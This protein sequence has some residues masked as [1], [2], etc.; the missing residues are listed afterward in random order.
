MKKLKHILSITAL[1]AL[2]SACSEKIPAPV[3][4]VGEIG[5]TI[6][7]GAGI[8]NSKAGLETKAIDGNHAKHVNMTES[9]Q[10]RLR[11]DGT[12][13]GKGLASDLVSKSTTGTINQ[14]TGT[15][16]KHNKINFSSTEQLYWDD[17]GTADPANTTSRSNGLT[18]YGI[19]VDGVSSAPAV[20]NWNNL[21]WPLVADQTEGWSSKDLLTSNN[22]RSGADG[23]LKF[24]EWKTYLAD[25]STAVSN[26]LEFTH[27]L[28]K[29][30][31]ILTAGQGFEESKFKTNPSVKLK[32]FKING[33]VDIE[34][35][36]TT[37]SGEAAEISAHLASGGANSNTAQFD[38]LV[39]PGTGWNNDTK[40]DELLELS[41]DGNVYHVSALKLYEKMT[42]V[43]H[44]QM[45]KGVNYVLNITVN[46][47]G[48]DVTA[49]IKDWE[50]V[51][52]ANEAPVIAISKTYGEGTTDFAKGFTFYRS[53]S[54]NGSYLGTGDNSAVSS[55]YTM[56]PKLYWPDHSTHY[57]FRGVWPAVGSTDGAAVA[58]LHDENDKT[59]IDVENCQYQQGKYPSDLMIGRPLKE[60]GTPDETCKVDAHKSGDVYPEGIC[61]TTGKI[62]LNFRYMMSQV[63]V[64]LTT[65]ADESPDKVVF[66]ENTKVE[67]IEGYTQGAILLG[68]CK[69][70]FA[71]KATLTYSMHNK[72]ASDYDSFHDAIIPQSLVNGNS[73]PTLKFKITVTD[74]SSLDSYETVMGISSIPVSSQIITEWEAG[75]KY[76]Y[77][78]HITKSKIDI[79]ATITDWDEASGSTDVIM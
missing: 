52:A 35:K 36:T 75:K 59:Y 33:T 47:T 78:L 41:A 73:D 25:N 20:S 79:K 26:I 1:L 53:L 54:K 51:T 12:W 66:D 58:K 65:S 16:N 70:D 71:G 45:D 44:S 40:G 10:L 43:S 49:T 57:F 11:I 23:T 28:T 48:I 14:E 68:E 60:N 46:K 38:A 74:G 76:T 6:V 13:V 19:A 42:S 30:T 63:I 31:V 5:N 37:P 4:T 77:T 61:A 62:N 24:N 15:D 17:Y 3:Y 69:S 22:I 72:A 8:N 64:E 21:A 67:I 56:T 9:T 50:D 32:P 7:L 18:I 34:A 29:I 55:T 27:A 2:A 39:Y